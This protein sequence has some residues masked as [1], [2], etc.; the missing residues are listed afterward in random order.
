MV[1]GN[2]NWNQATPSPTTGLSSVPTLGTG[3]TLGTLASGPVGTIVGSLASNILGN[4]FSGGDDL[5]DP[6]YVATQNRIA[7]LASTKGQIHGA[8]QAAKETGLHPLAALGIPTSGGTVGKL[9]RD[10]AGG[11]GQNIQRAINASVPNA[12]EK[13]LQELTLERAKLDNDLLRAQISE[14]TKQAGDPPVV[15][16]PDE[17]VRASL[18]TP[19]L[20]AGSDKPEPMTKKKLVATTPYG[21]IHMNVPAS[22]QVDEMGELYGSVK[23]IEYLVKRGYAKYMNGGYRLIRKIKNF[24][25]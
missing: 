15:V 16:N 19:D 24:R 18:K 20:S 25:K 23:G 17:N 8:V 4:V 3:T 12:Y 5:P 9:S 6:Q 10:A 2:I 1:S 22:G 21:S 7:A 11:M 13:Q 14:V